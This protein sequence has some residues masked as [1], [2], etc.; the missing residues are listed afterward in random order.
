MA[1]LK[2]LSLPRLELCAALLLVRLASKLLPKLQLNI[3]KW[4]FWTDSTIV[5]FWISSS[6][7][8]WKTFVAHRVSEIQ[9]KTSSTEWRYIGT[10]ENPVDNIS[11]SCCP[12]KLAKMTLWWSGPQWLEMALTF[13][14]QP[15]ILNI[16]SESEF[17]LP[18][19][20]RNILCA[21][22]E[23]GQPDVFLSRF[24][25]LSKCLRTIGYC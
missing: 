1:P 8:K 3:K 15:V 14:P 4:C 7:T 5:I 6:S 25:S 19:I 16:D 20:K 23:V 9:D 2:V 17:N 13:R 21:V 18:K 22:C 10:K 11:H 12:L 24:S